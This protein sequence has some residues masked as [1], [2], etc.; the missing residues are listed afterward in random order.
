MRCFVAVWVPVEVHAAVAGLRSAVEAAW[1]GEAAWEP[2]AKWHV[3][4]QFLGETPATVL[5]DLTAALAGV[6]RRHRPFPLAVAGPGVF[7]RG[8]RVN[9]LWAGLAGAVGELLALRDDVVAVTA[10]LG[11]QAD[12]FHPHVT[13]GRPH[14][15]PGLPADQVVSAV[16]RLPAPVTGQV[17]E[18]ATLRLCRS[19]G[20]YH[21]VA[22]WPLLRT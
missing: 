4:L 3:T 2:P 1:P 17:F 6:A 11:F 8:H 5:P 13:L 21:T 18:V 20:G 7:R 15:A 19:E 14:G 10:P 22:E 12:A 9:V 16:E